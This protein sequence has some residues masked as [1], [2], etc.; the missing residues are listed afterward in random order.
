M[1]RKGIRPITS[2]GTHKYRP[3]SIVSTQFQD[4]LKVGIGLVP[5]I[6]THKRLRVARAERESDQPQLLEN[7][8]KV[9]TGHVTAIGR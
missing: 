7:K 6:G 2:I 1:S 9:G 5:T 4:K 8:L 3:Q